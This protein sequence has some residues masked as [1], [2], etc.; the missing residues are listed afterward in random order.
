MAIKFSSWWRFTWTA[1]WR[2]SLKS[3]GR[4][5]AIVV[6]LPYPGTFFGIIVIVGENEVQHRIEIGWKK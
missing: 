2:V 3:H 4:F 1:E 6:A 5:L